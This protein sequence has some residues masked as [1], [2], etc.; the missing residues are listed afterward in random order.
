MGEAIQPIIP[1]T[2]PNRRFK[3]HVNT[4]MAVAVFPDGRRMVTSSVENTL[5]LWD[6]KDGVVLKKMEGH[7][8]WVREVAV[9]GDGQLIA[10]GDDNGEFIAWDAE[11]GESLT[12]A[13]KGHSSWIC[14]LD[15][16]ADSATLTTGSWDRKTK[17]WNTKPWQ[18][19]GDPIDCHAAV[20]CVRY[21]PSRC[22]ELQVLAI[23][24]DK[25]IQIWNPRTRECTAKFKAAI[26]SAFNTSLAWTP[27]GTRLLSGGSASDPTIREWDTSTWKQAG[28]PWCGHTDAINVIT[29]NSTGTLVA[30]ASDDKHVRLWRLSDRRTIAVFKHSKTVWCATFSADGKYI[31]SGGFHKK[32]SEW[33]VPEHPLLEAVE[34]SS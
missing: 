2:R 25:D 12:Q 10:S 6:L 7:R 1:I 21:S 11:S 30:S 5:R 31:F 9:S 28:D 19:Q 18:L 14:S 32:I 20:N 22:G 13:I 15:F 29:V 23:A 34:V 8:G 24:T 26:D 16:S 33:A 27:D 17:L 4:V 3:G